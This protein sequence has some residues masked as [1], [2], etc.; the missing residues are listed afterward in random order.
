METNFSHE[1][2]LT[3]INEMINRARNNFQK[4]KMYSLIYWGYTVAAIAIL[5]Y[6]L[7]HLLHNPNQS[8]WVWCLILP[9]WMVSYF[10]N[11]YVEKAVLVKTHI[12]EIGDKTW[13]GYGIGV[14]VFIAVI[15]TVA[16]KYQTPLILS[17]ITPVIM[18]MVGICEF[19]AASLYRYK[20][21]IGVAALFWMGAIGCAFLPVDL[22]FIALAA[23]MIVGFVI[24]GHVLNYQAKK[25]HV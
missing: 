19:A 21:W 20:R 5:N 6:A 10:I 13:K 11:R 2:S 3:L 25:S 12:D 9:A 23:C 16:I 14:F 15:F 24:P 18:I 1:Q 4:E 17:L 7:L 22:Q 8:F